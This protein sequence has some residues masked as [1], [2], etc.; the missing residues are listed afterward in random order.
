MKKQ[1]VS[2]VSFI[3]FCFISLSTSVALAT[4]SSIQL[5]GAEEQAAELIQQIYGIGTAEEQ[6]NLLLQAA[7]I[8][9]DSPNIL[10]ECASLL[11]ILNG[12]ANYT[13]Q[14]ETMLRKVVSLATGDLRA[15]ALQALG[16]MYLTTQGIDVATDFIRQEL[17]KTPKDAVLLVMLAKV[18]YFNDQPDESLALIEQILLETPDDF[19]AER[20][21]AILFINK[22]RYEESLSAFDQL[23]AK[24]PDEPQALAGRYI[25]YSWLGQFDMAIQALDDEIRN[26]GNESL[27]LERVKI[28]L[29]KQQDPEIALREAES[30][31][32]AHPD[33]L[34]VYISKMN[35]FIT[36]KRYDEAMEVAD[37]IATMNEGLGQL[38][39][40]MVLFAM[41]KWQEAKPLILH[42]VELPY[43]QK[44]WADVVTLYLQGYDDVPS[45]MGAVMKSFAII[46]NEFYSYMRLGQIHAYIGDYLQAARAFYRA[47][48]YADEDAQAMQWLIITM[49]DA[50]RKD[51]AEKQLSLME[52]RYP[53]WYET[54]LART[55]YEN[56]FSL[57]DEALVSFTAF[58]EK[59]PYSASTM[60]PI[61]ATLLMAVGDVK[62]LRLMEAWMNE[63]AEDTLTANDWVQYAQVLLYAEETGRAK[64]A[65]D[66][67]EALL[68][69]N[70][71]LFPIK[72]RSEKKILLSVRAELARINGDMDACIAFLREA[73]ELGYVLLSDT[74]CTAD[75]VIYPSEAYDALYDIYGPGTEAWDITVH[76]K[77]PN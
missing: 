28:R 42:A 30:L 61:E 66:T 8:A 62:G 16:D 57:N 22:G 65:L 25:A 56:A 68:Q 59:Y 9:P 69:E 13:T 54:M 71:A 11:G 45:A 51:D 32:K 50:G 15:E 17:E 36:L 31:I 60:Q 27:W 6:A 10:I 26:T 77:M 5:S 76:P 52:A 47:E 70:E 21:R 55:L 12:N 29:F 67:A 1:F 20:L 53:G 33:W 24:Y 4:A 73:G 48:T 49:I 37:Q 75:D 18:Y 63:Q 34:D 38:M 39:Q 2:L 23:E 7:E 58:R 40:S 14:I 74:L 35:A 41:D 64:D 72:T 46:G 43:L 44:A 19:E 3:L